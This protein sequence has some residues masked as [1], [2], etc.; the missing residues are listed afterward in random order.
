M[1]APEIMTTSDLSTFHDEPCNLCRG[2]DYEVV[3]P[4]SLRAAP[5]PDSVKIT[6]G[7]YNVCGQIVRCNNCGLAC[8]NPRQ[9]SETVVSLYSQMEDE[10]YHN[11]A[12]GRK[13]AFRKILTQLRKLGGPIEGP[14][15]LLDVGAATG[16]LL[17]E[18]EQMGWRASGVEPSTWAAGVAREK[19][20]LDVH[21]GTLEDSPFAS[22][23][24]DF[25]T[26]VDVIEHVVDP[27]GLLE[28]I[29]QKLKPG[30]IVCVVT[31]D[32][33]SF[34]AKFLKQNWW[35]VRQAHIYYFTETSLK[36]MLEETGYRI[37]KKK[38]Y[39]WTFSVDYW[40][41]RFENFSPPIYAFAQ[42]LKRRA[43]FR[44][45][46]NWNIRINFMDSFEWYLT[47]K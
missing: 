46:F 37:I 26:A 6:D 8:V 45:A 38:R 15:R 5:G 39:A 11:E 22:G 41:S 10:A 32:F 19:Y 1:S 7:E 31:P 21:C 18:A 35:H 24:F 4:N 27:R 14:P 43:L 25:I 47:K 42:F 9:A 40:A 36:R 13:K 34:V 3:Y 12:A 23:E 30:G 16:L 29:A 17:Q 28:T 20:G 33:D 2:S 44:P